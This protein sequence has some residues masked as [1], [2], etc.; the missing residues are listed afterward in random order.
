MGRRIS[1]LRVS[2]LV[3]GHSPSPPHAPQAS[4]PHDGLHTRERVPQLPHVVTSL[5]PGP[6]TP[7]LAQVEKGPQ[8]A[9]PSVTWQVRV[10][11]PQSPQGCSSICPTVHAGAMQ[12]PSDQ[13]Q[14]AVQVATCVPPVPHG[15]C[16]VELGAHTPC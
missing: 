4:Q 7:G 5:V 2:V 13:V 10:C 11:L 9:P 8:T 6:Q 15:R 1:Q 12:A 14:L 16:S 3:G